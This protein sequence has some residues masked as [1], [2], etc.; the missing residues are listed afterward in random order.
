LL[1]AGNL[2]LLRWPTAKIL[3]T[4]FRLFDVGGVT[5][6]V[7]MA[8]MLIASAMQHTKTLYREERIS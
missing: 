6:M 3:G 2:A 1:A 4:Q 8:L 5:G 7:G